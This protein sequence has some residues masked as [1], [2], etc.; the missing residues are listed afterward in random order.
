MRSDFTQASTARQSESCPFHS[1]VLPPWRQ[2]L[3]F[4]LLFALFASC[5]VQPVERGEDGQPQ[6]P[7][8]AVV[9]FGFDEQYPF[10]RSEQWL[11]LTIQLKNNQSQ[12][13]TGNLLMQFKNGREHY[14]IPFDLPAQ[15][16]TTL[17]PIVYFG[18]GLDELEFY[19]ETAGRS[20][21]IAV[22][23]V[24][25]LLG[26]DSQ[27]AAVLSG[28]RGSHPYLAQSPELDIPVVRRVLY[29]YPAL[30]PRVPLGYL[31]IDTLIWDGGPSGALTAAQEKALDEWIQMGGT[32][33]LAAGE[34]WQELNNSPF[35]LYSPV[36][37]ENS[38]V[39]PAG[40]E[41]APVDNETPP[42]LARQT[43]MAT[44]GLVD[45]GEL[46]V[47]LRAGETPFLVTRP[48][49]AGKVIY[50][51]STIQEPLFQDAEIQELL[52]RFLVD[53]NFIFPPEPVNELDSFVTS[54]LRFT[55][56]AE[57]P[58]TQF[59]ALYL[60]LYIILVAPVNYLVFRWVGRLEWAWLTVPVWAI[61]FAVGVYYI[62]ALRQ[63]SQ[64]SVSQVS[65]IEAG[66]S[67]NYAKATTYSTIY[68][69]VRQWYTLSLTNPPAYPLLPMLFDDQTATEQLSA[70]QLNMEM[71]QAGAQINDFLI[72]HWS[73]RLLKA[74]HRFDLGEGIDFQLQ[75]TDHQ[76]RGYLANQSPYPI[77]SPVIFYQ[78]NTIPLDF[79]VLPPGE[80]YRFERP[81][82]QLGSPP[83]GRGGMM[84]YG[85]GMMG[86]PPMMM[87]RRGNYDF[88]QFNSDSKRMINEALREMYASQFNQYNETP[89]VALFMGLLPAPGLNLEING[90]RIEPT[91]DSMLTVSAKVQNLQSG[92]DFESTSF[93]Y[94]QAFRE[95]PGQPW[96]FE[97]IGG[98]PPP[99]NSSEQALL[100][101]QSSTEAAF[102]QFFQVPPRGEPITFAMIDSANLTEPYRQRIDP[103]H[104]Q[105]MTIQSDYTQ[106]LQ[107]NGIRSPNQAGLNRGRRMANPY[108]HPIGEEFE[109][110][111]YDFTRQRFVRLSER[112]Q[113]NGTVS[114]PASLIEPARGALVFRIRSPLTD[115]AFIYEP[116]LDFQWTMRLSEAHDETKRFL[117]H[118]TAEIAP[119]VLPYA[120]TGAALRTPS[121][122][123]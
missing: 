79:G 52:N 15:G 8:E 120:G 6:E 66:S 68:S 26:N 54:F 60:G 32:L 21:P 18:L 99:F 118:S 123:R 113:P 98:P 61:I 89:G 91:G 95:D 109:L 85:M 90:E 34:S 117:G 115:R 50:V 86:G 48:W 87:A 64:V 74:Q 93:I 57:L 55:L 56:Q 92:V 29:T 1:A 94:A 107:R 82:S 31:N 119:E 39:I 84:G 10:R 49:G 96:Q 14:R 97:R 108:G 83:R 25:T 59:I 28:E 11:P 122:G 101:W 9:T 121:S 62:G 81:Y 73:Q 110:H 88:R 70:E 77:E 111:V 35:G 72:Y 40:T 41:L 27:V 76:L 105:S 47:W 43:V 69:P 100:D 16:E 24:S 22:T 4:G 65:V 44:G 63:Q 102:N 67:A 75:A 5:G 7:F 33:V 46:K 23:T 112:I 3:L 12:P 37:A 45:A 104:I 78:Q 36:T 38:R 103:A 114:D 20:I 17:K 13:A 80:D 51:A 42:T 58:S 53:S 71:T 106:M 2:A 30:L 19:A 116:R